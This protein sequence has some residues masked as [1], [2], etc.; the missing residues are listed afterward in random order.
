MRSGRFVVFSLQEANLGGAGFWSN[1]FGWVTTLKSATEF[2]DAETEALNLPRSQ[3][4][5]AMW[6]EIIDTH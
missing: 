2:T 1:E 6:L 5:D 4:N 3:G